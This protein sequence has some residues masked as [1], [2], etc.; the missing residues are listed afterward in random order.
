MKAVIM[1]GGE[2]SRLRPLTCTLPKPM[3]KLCGRPVSE[4]ILD[5]LSKHS[6]T[7]AVFTLRYLGSQIEEHFDSRRYKGISLDFSYE[8]TP[9]GTAGCVK[10]AA[11]LLNLGEDE[12]FVIISGD[13]MCDFDLSAAISYHIKKGADATI[14]TSR[15]EDPR[16]YGCVISDKGFVTGFSEK[17]SYTGAVSDYVNTGVYILS[18]KI[19]KLIPDNT[20]WDFSKDVF[21]QMLKSGMK[22]AAFEEKGYWCDIGDFSSFKRC[23]RDML[24]GLVSC[25]FKRELPVIEGAKIIAPCYIGSNVKIGAGSVVNPG[26][27]VEDNVNIG[28]SCKLYECVVSEG[29]FL[30]DRT[31]CNG[32]VICENAVMEQGSAVYEDAVLGSGSILGQDSSLEPKVKIWDNKTIRRGVMQREDIKYG[33]TSSTVLDEKGVSGETNSDITPAFMTKLGS[34]AAAVFGD[35]V[36][37]SCGIGNAASVLKACFCAGFS[38]AGGR[39]TDCGV[40]SLPALIHISRIMN[41]SGIINIEVSSK[42]K[43]TILNKAGLPLT[44]VQERKLEAALNRG[45]YR[46]AEWDG[47]G[48]IKAF[49]NASLLYTGALESASDF[50]CRYKV[51][52]NCSNPLIT[53]AAAA[54]FK[55]ISNPSGEALTVNI[56]R[57]GTKAELYVSEREKADYT[58]LVAIVGNDLMQKGF[59]IAVPLEFPSSTEEMAK[60][61]GR[62]VRRFYKCSNDNSDK[63]AR[64]LAASQPFLFDGLILALNSLR[65]IS[66][67][68]MTLGNYLQKLPKL[69]TENRFLHIHCPPQRILSKLAEK[70]NGVSEGIFLGS[71]GNRVLLRSNRQGDGLFLFAESYSQETAKALCDEV[72][73]KVRMMTAEGH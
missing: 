15:V 66:A 20:M 34:S 58:K 49:K 71:E 11:E 4:Y 40:A 13:A 62:T 9:L 12:S 50:S 16:E 14:I 19:L 38:G 46:N 3:V 29:A 63:G 10:K 72:E 47:F 56:N 17:P 21:P 39:V 6:C 67:S 25:E 35:R 57:E 37:V 8:D 61:A 30:S 59:D 32:G 54:P 69:E 5:L 41:A 7:E 23:Q 28:K 55:K 73:M 68:Y 43:I 26:C 24:R 53:S 48:E 27:V 70:S 31:K 22:L 52:V 36:I 1:A 60:L 64:E 33:N 42:S 2:G 45:D 44:R 18:P 51:S 65:I